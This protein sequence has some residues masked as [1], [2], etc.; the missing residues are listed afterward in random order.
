MLPGDI[1][2]MEK[3]AVYFWK[4]TA[5]LEDGRTVESEFGKLLFQK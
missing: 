5:T 1:W 2:A 4:V 3:G